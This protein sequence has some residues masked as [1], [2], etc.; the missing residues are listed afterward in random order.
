MRQGD[1]GPFYAILTPFKG[2]Y[3]Y[4][5][6]K[7][8]G[9]RHRKTSPAISSTTH[10]RASAAHRGLPGTSAAPSQVSPPDAVAR[11]TTRNFCPPCSQGLRLRIRQQK[12]IFPQ[13]HCCGQSPPSSPAWL[14]AGTAEPPPAPRPP[15]TTKRREGSPGEGQRPSGTF[16]PHS[17][18]IAMAARP[19]TARLG[20]ARPDGGARQP[21]L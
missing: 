11:H 13:N 19:G 9:K 17:P 2:F 15:T 18:S 14:H 7:Y 5:S 12:A 16:L 1:D 6:P 21:P 20:S 10:V 8:S 4:L 3:D